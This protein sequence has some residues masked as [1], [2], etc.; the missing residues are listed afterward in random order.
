MSYALLQTYLKNVREA[1]SRREVDPQGCGDRLGRAFSLR[2]TRAQKALVRVAADQGNELA[3]AC[4]A[5]LIPAV[6]S[7]YGAV[8][9][10]VPEFHIVVRLHF[11]VCA[12]V[13]SGDVTAAFA[14]Q[15]E[16]FKTFLRIYDRD[17]NWLVPALQSIIKDFIDLAEMAD[18][19]RSKK[20]GISSHTLLCGDCITLIREAFTKS[21][22]DAKR[23]PATSRKIAVL[24]VT[25]C[26][27]RIYFK[28]N[29][30]QSCDS[31]LKQVQSQHVLAHRSYSLKSFPKAHAV[32][33]QYYVGRLHLFGGRYDEAEDALD[34]ALANCHKSSAKNLRLIL[35]SLIPAKMVRGVLPA[36]EMLTRYDMQLYTDLTRSVRTGNIRLFDE[37]LKKNQITFVRLGIYFAFESVRCIVYRNLFKRLHRICASDSGASRVS[38]RDLVRVLE[39]QDDEVKGSEDAEC[40]LANLIYK[41]LVKG[42]IH[43]GSQVLVLSKTNPFPSLPKKQM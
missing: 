11:E 23:P 8:G 39:I 22:R 43:H 14:K 42:Y 29:M 21:L 2:V 7:T 17:F 37:V 9:D 26:L 10:Q 27:I 40:I 30:L 33:F 13:E 19:H 3:T 6:R 41:K 38:I 16:M 20:T 15:R 1:V 32:A 24:H 31:I 28:L 12:L 25:V 34:F 35:L 4:E 18:A 5:T 36:Q